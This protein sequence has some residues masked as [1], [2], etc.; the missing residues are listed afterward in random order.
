MRTLF[1]ILFISMMFIS[2]SYNNRGKFVITDFSK[3]TTFQVKTKSS[4]PTTLWLYIKGS[5]NDTIMINEVKT[6][7]NPGKVDSLQMDEY[8]PDFSIRFK[9]FKATK[10]K[11]EVEYY[12]P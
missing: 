10:G 3:D 2:C 6:K 12:L 8:Y 5:T 4:S 7:V 11:I 1:F 9:H